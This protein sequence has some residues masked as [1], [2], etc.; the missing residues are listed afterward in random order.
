MRVKKFY[1]LHI[2]ELREGQFYKVVIQF[3]N[4]KIHTYKTKYD[5]RNLQVRNLNY[6]S[7]LRYKHI[8]VCK[9]LMQ[10]NLYL[11]MH[12][13][14]ADYFGAVISKIENLDGRTNEAKNLPW[15]FG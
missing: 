13:D 8:D 2:K 5:I 14:L 7:L 9:K 10:E 15:F 1:S 6:C 11:S 12:S 3:N 4:G